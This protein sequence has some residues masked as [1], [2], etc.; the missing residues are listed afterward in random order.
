[1]SDNQNQKNNKFLDADEINTLVSDYWNGTLDPQKKYSFTGS[2]HAQAFIKI[3]LGIL[4]KCRIT[5]DIVKMAAKL[6]LMLLSEPTI[7]VILVDRRMKIKDIV[8]CSEGYRPRFS[9]FIEEISHQCITNKVKKCILI[10]N[11]P[12]KG[13]FIE[14]LLDIDKLYN[15]LMQKKL[16]LIDAI[17][18]IGT[19]V[20][21]MIYPINNSGYNL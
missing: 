8:V 9:E 18:V 2:L 4:Q 15:E 6:Y 21:A 1:M 20:T 3:S 10:Y 14:E 7:A 17:R 5:N 13:E 16:I 19:S 12:F 11:F